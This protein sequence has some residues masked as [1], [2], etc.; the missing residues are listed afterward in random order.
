MQQEF[1][2]GPDSSENPAQA[3]PPPTTAEV[4]AP[5]APKSARRIP[6]W[7]L[8]TTIALV[9]LV[10][11]AAVGYV[12]L[13][14][15][16]A[17]KDAAAIAI[18]AAKVA[19]QE[20]GTAAEPGSQALAESQKSKA[21]LDEA[22]SLYSEGYLVRAGKYRAATRKAD[23]ARRSARAVTARVEALAAD[24]STADSNDSVGLYFALY[25]QYPRTHE[26]QAA[27]AARVGGTPRQP[28]ERRL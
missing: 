25:K 21:A 6:K 16:L 3:V 28:F 19:V 5:V 4:A 18:A 15:S 27:L 8:I 26:G 22:T 13:G 2:I 1:P 11:V 20:A 17:A 12:S 9:V 23:D 14:R 7:L 10:A 24:A